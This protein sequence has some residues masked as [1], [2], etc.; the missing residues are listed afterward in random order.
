MKIKKRYKLL[1][2]IIGIILG[3]FGGI[4]LVEII[5]WRKRNENFQTNQRKKG[6]RKRGMK[7]KKKNTK[8]KKGD[9]VCTTGYGRTAKWG[10][11]CGKVNKTWENSA[12][13]VWDGLH[14][15]DEMS[16]KEI[17]KVSKK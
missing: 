11:Y 17:K 2:S 16:N 10:K 4:L 1:Q 13:V 3:I 5:E 7:M 15:G 12:E 6:R 14:F 9:K 8:F